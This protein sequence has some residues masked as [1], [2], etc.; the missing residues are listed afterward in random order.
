MYRSSG[1]WQFSWPDYSS[2]FGN[3]SHLAFIEASA[4]GYEEAATWV[5][6][7]DARFEKLVNGND[8]MVVTVTMVP[9]PATLSALGA[10]LPVFRRKRR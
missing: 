5:T 10:C 1:Q 6:L 4:D 8:Q 9:E 2:S 3:T 7:Y